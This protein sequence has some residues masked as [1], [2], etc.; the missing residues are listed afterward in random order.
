MHAL[1]L[2]RGQSCGNPKTSKEADLEIKRLLKI[3]PMSGSDRRREDLAIGVDMAERRG[4]AAHVWEDELSGYGS[5][6]SWS[7]ECPDEEEDYA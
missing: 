1:A 7:A 3:R 6:A 5:S 2:A 4:D